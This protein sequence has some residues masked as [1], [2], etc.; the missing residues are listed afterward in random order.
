MHTCILTYILSLSLP[1]PPL[2]RRQAQLGTGWGYSWWAWCRI[3][4][5]GGRSSWPPPSSP[6]PHT[7]WGPSYQT[8]SHTPYSSSSW[9]LPLQVKLWHFFLLY[10]FFVLLQLRFIIIASSKLVKII[11]LPFNVYKLS[12]IWKNGCCD[13]CWKSAWLRGREESKCRQFSSSLW[14]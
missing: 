6:A 14:L 8:S 11:N 12:V 9:T 1:P 3:G 4:G 5:A 10:Y 2:Y 13:L 7:C